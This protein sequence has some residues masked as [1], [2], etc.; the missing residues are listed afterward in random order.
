MKK[1]YSVLLLCGLL[2]ASALCQERADS[3]IPKDNSVAFRRSLLWTVVPVAIGGGIALTGAHGVSDHAQIATGLSIAGLGLLIGP[4]A[5][6]IYAGRP[7]PLS[8][9]GLRL[10]VGAVGFVVVAHDAIERPSENV[11]SQFCMF[12]VPFALSV[13]YD[14]ATAAKSAE[15][16]NKKH[17]LATWHIQ[18][19]YFAQQEA[20]GLSLSLRF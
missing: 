14:I 7:L 8:G 17:G 3:L 18:P 16:Y 15:R 4:S 20:M 9:M 2:S 1:S 10:L 13:V 5:G 11:A 19:D 6:H 12:S